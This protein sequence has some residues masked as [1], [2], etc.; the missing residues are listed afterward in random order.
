MA[1]DPFRPDHI[2]ATHPAIGAFAITPSDGADLA[3]AIRQITIGTA[4]GILVWRGIDGVSQTTGPLPLGTYPI[5]AHRIM[6]T[7]TTATGLTGW[8]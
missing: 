8:V 1:I 2:A 5:A 7:G 6:A 4:G 3:L